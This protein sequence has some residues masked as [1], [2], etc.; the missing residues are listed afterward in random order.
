MFLKQRVCDP[1]DQE[2]RGYTAKR[3]RRLLNNIFDYALLPENCFLHPELAPIGLDKPF[4]FEKNIQSK[5]IF[6]QTYNPQIGV[7]NLVCK[8]CEPDAF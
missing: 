3:F 4:L 7:G 5:D 2:G 1:K 8:I 6:Y